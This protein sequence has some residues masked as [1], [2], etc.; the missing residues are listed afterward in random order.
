MYKNRRRID[1]DKRM[2]PNCAPP[3]GVSLLPPSRRLATHAALGTTRAPHRG[4]LGTLEH[5]GY[6]EISRQFTVQRH[7]RSRE[8]STSNHVGA[9]RTRRPGPP[10]PLQS[11]P[12]KSPA[13]P[14][15]G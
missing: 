2:D 14:Q 8:M 3:D 4:Q 12:V 7:V 1:V 10:I 13:S 6:V 11:P 15:S 9:E 5:Q